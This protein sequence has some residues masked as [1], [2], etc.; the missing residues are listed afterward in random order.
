MPIFI[1][2]AARAR[3][4]DPDGEL[5]L[6]RG[7]VHMGIPQC[8]SSYASMPHEDIAECF[9]NDPMR[10][11]E[12][13][14][15]F[16]QLYV[17]RDKIGAEARIAKAKALGYQALVVTVESNVI[18]KRDDDDRFHASEDFLATG[19]VQQD[20][21][22]MPGDEP[23]VPR[24]SHCPSLEWADLPWIRKLWG[25]KPIILKGIQT[26]EDAA[27]AMQYGVQGV[28][29][30]NHGGR[31]LDYAPTAVETLCEIRRMCPD[32]LRK[33]E[34]YVDG[35]VKRGS[36]VVKALCLGAKAVAIGR[37][38]MFALSAY[39]TPGVLKA[40]QSEYFLCRRKKKSAILTRQF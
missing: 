16:F 30:S 31:Q 10:R 25:D 19:E 8:V 9:K 34:I 32:V 15:L 6:T 27:L 18:G 26:A 1:S 20:E 21:I 13:S 36:D 37:G 12:G 3:M 11:G 28:Y 35:G 24:A 7:A 2:P 33:L 38:F 40:I 23:G 5:C 22:P 17:P 14:G 4:G 29:L 39:G